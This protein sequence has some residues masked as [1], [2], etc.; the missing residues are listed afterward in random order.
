M[1]TVTGRLGAPQRVKYVYAAKNGRETQARIAQG[2]TKDERAGG[3][4]LQAG[5]FSRNPFVKW[6]RVSRSKVER[7]SDLVG[8]HW[9]DRR[10]RLPC[11]LWIRS[12]RHLFNAICPKLTTKN[13]PVS[14]RKPEHTWIR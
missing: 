8:I 5:D 13:S 12:N 6:S 1:K 2:E 11:F 9:A 4:G 7:L 10:S 14:L 3:A